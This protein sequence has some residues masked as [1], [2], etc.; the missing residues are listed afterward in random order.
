MLLINIYLFVLTTYTLEVKFIQFSLLLHL[1]RIK[2]RK[3][4][5]NFVLLSCSYVFL[6]LQT[7][8]LYLNRRDILVYIL[9]VH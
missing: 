8:A 5:E 9:T 1:N 4:A 3:L 7:W 2:A 6:L